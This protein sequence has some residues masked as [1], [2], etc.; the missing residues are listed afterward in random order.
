MTPSSN[1]TELLGKARWQRSTDARPATG[2]DRREKQEP[3]FEA[4]HLAHDRHVHDALDP[5]LL[6]VKRGPCH[7]KG[8]VR[9]NIL[10]PDLEA[11]LA[12]L[13]QRRVHVDRVPPA[14][15]ADVFIK[16]FI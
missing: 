2:R 6:R 16:L 1:G 5:H 3:A 4:F 14:A 15:D 8:H 7:V 12:E 13:P 9:A 10:L 11:L